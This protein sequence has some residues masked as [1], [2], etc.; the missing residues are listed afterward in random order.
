MFVSK[1]IRKEISVSVFRRRMILKRFCL[2]FFQFAL[3]SAAAADDLDYFEGSA[4]DLDSCWVSS[5]L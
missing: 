4:G 5:E 2:V 1:K 3:L